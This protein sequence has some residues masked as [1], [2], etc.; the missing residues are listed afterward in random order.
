MLFCVGSLYAEPINFHNQ[1]LTIFS[2]RNI[3]SNDMIKAMGLFKKKEGPAETK[4]KECGLELHDPVR[5][6]RHMKKA[7]KHA[8]QRNFDE[9]GGTST[10]GMW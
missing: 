7:H 4:C 5:L 1:I 10:G 9:P 3:I 2:V 8:P 6:D